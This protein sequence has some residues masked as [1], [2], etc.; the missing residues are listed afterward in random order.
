MNQKNDVFLEPEADARW[1]R[2]GMEWV[3]KML[4]ELLL[5]ALIIT[6]L[7][8]FWWM[9]SGGFKPLA[10]LFVF[11]PRLWPSR[12][13]TAGYDLVF[14]FFPF[15]W[16]N[17]LNSVLVSGLSSVGV[18]LSTSLGAFAFSRMRFR[19]KETI[20]NLALVTLMVPWVVLLIPRFIMFKSVGWVDT[21]LPLIVPHFFGSAYFLFMLRQFYASIPPELEEAAMIDGASW[22]Q[23]YAL[24]SL[25]I[26]KPALITMFLFTFLDSWN[27]LLTP[28]IYL[29]GL[30]NLTLT[31]LMAG[32]R[33]AYHSG[34]MMHAEMAGATITV[35]PIV[36]IYLFTQ[37][38]IVSSMTFSGLKG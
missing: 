3:G 20:F 32:I 24:I 15:V 25:P 33:D 2:R 37:R 6:A 34:A 22:P 17:F 26:I 38:Y 8:P 28:I 23:I 13:V 14:Q 5:L 9:I 29:N 36:I 21:L 30:E 18:I 4:L 7:L 12:W 27:D 31:S 10:D 1:L 11:P 35:V 19:G 16:R